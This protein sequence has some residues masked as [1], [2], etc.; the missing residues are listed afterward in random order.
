MLSAVWKTI[1]LFFALA[2]FLVVGVNALMTGEDLI[3]AVAK[4]VGSFVGCW[5]VMGC[6]GSA[7]VTVVE[8]SSD[9]AVSE[10]AEEAPNDSERG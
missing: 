9:Q 4:A 7:L 1:S 2:A 3:W 6:L 8:R 10:L 5:I